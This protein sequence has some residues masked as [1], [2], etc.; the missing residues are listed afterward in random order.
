MVIKNERSPKNIMIPQ[1]VGGF[2]FLLAIYS[3]STCE[4]IRT[5]QIYDGFDPPAD[6][7]TRFSLGLYSRESPMVNDNE[8]TCSWFDGDDMEI[9]Y[10]FPYLLA[11]S[12]NTLSTLAGLFNV[13][14]SLFMW[15]CPG[16]THRSSIAILSVN[17]FLCGIFACFSQAVY[18][19]GACTMR[20]CNIQPDKSIG[21]LCFQNRCSADKGSIISGLSVC[22]WFGASYLTYRLRFRCLPRRRRKRKQAEDGSNR[23][24]LLRALSKPGSQSANKESFDEED[25]FIDRQLDDIS[26]FLGLNGDRYL[27]Y[28]DDLDD[29]S[30]QADVLTK[31]KNE[32]D[33]KDKDDGTVFPGGKGERS[34][35]LD[36]TQIPLKRPTICKDSATTSGSTVQTEDDSV[37][38]SNNSSADDVTIV[39][40]LLSDER[41]KHLDNIE[42]GSQI[43]ISPLKIKREVSRKSFLGIPLLEE[44]L[45]MDTELGTN[46]ITRVHRLRSANAEMHKTNEGANV[47]DGIEDSNHPDKRQEAKSSRDTVSLIGHFLSDSALGTDQ[48]QDQYPLDVLSHDS[49]ITN[50]VEQ[51]LD[52]IPSDEVQSHQDNSPKI[53]ARESKTEFGTIKETLS[54][55]V[56]WSS[57]VSRQMQEYSHVPVNDIETLDVDIEIGLSSQ[58]DTQ[59][60]DALEECVKEH[61]I[62]EAGQH[63]V[64]KKASATRDMKNDLSLRTLSQFELICDASNNGD[65]SILVPSLYSK[66]LQSSSSSASPSSIQLSKGAEKVHIDGS[67]DTPTLK[68]DES[69][70]SMPLQSLEVDFLSCKEE[71]IIRPPFVESVFPTISSDFRSNSTHLKEASLNSRKSRGGWHYLRNKFERVCNK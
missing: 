66:Q 71:D 23:R 46:N 18:W 59:N 24:F 10:D 47:G 6:I 13:F 55:E 29:L 8:G 67:F 27:D 60:D 32:D 37:S 69:L 16:C 3:T 57:N 38:A 34:S 58:L 33:D 4:F 1:M 14:I 21:T 44:E 54:V 48:G 28:L 19:T 17:Y 61:I 49:A 52:E 53:Q 2:A 25:K 39:A 22:M 50:L 12:G 64:I 70:S 45:E 36:H 62:I 43:S 20:Q 5:I 26:E 51:V 30:V 31:H 68:A 35:D 63:Q 9:L 15:C 7:K 56:E 40:S 42:V 65:S 41:Q 11:I